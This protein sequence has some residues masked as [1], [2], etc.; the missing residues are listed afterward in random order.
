MPLLIEGRAD[1]DI[2]LRALHDQPAWQSLAD[3]MQSANSA[4]ASSPAC[5]RLV[6]QD[7]PRAIQ[8]Y[9][10]RVGLIAVHFPDFTDGRGY[11]S[12][13]ILRRQLGWPG[14]LRATGSILPDQWLALMR[15]G[16]DQIEVEQATELQVRHQLGLFSTSYQPHY[17]LPGATRVQVEASRDLR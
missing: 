15:C 7:D 2:V 4:S 10:D 11:S 14:P 17:P 16:F 3:F 6:P 13:R 1:G 5:L 8:P 12:A 9:L